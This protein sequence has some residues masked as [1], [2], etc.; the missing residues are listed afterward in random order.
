MLVIFPSSAYD[1]VMDKLLSKTEYIMYREC[2]QNAWV[3]RHR[4]DIHDQ[5]EMSEFEESLL[6]MGNE[7]EELARG[8]FPEGYL[9]ERRS[10]GAVE[11]TKQLISERK[12]IIFQAVFTTDAYLAA[13]DVMVWNEGAGAYDLYEIKMSSTQ[14]EDADGKVKVDRKKEERYSFDLAF[15]AQ[16]VEACG[17]KLHKKYLVRLNRKYVRNGE[18]DYSQLFILEDRTKDMPAYQDLAKEEMIR[19]HAALQSTRIPEGRCPCFY[20]G[21]SKHCTTF[22]FTNPDVP[23]KNS[24]HDLNRIGSSKRYLRELLDAGILH[25]EHVPENEDLIKSEKKYNQVRVHKTQEPLIN[26][27]ALRSEL[28]K[29]EFPLYF[30]DYEAYPTAIPPFSGYRPYQQIVF[31]YSLHVLHAPDAEVQQFGDLILGGDPSEKIAEQL[32]AHIGDKGSVIVWYKTYEDCRNRELAQLAPKYKD[33]FEHI[34]SRTYDLMDI[35][36]GQLY[37]HPG[38]EG[39][40]S[41]KKVLPVLVPEL[42]YAG[43]PVKSGTDAIEGYRQ[44][45]RGELEGTARD[46][47]QIDMLEYC[48]LDT[49][50][51]Y[52]IWK[53][54][55]AIAQ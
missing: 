30:L 29:L 15:Q 22:A 43:L 5:Y 46:Q 14:K 7:V 9:V 31:Q 48:K 52:E 54:F 8:M 47:K 10:E 6:E 45:T 20:R 41:I 26:T 34:I 37:V 33:F 27:E 49:L 11:L 36:E 4:S 17:V 25:I 39:R 40:A 2:P 53:Q 38:F 32:R 24:V 28:S 19:A 23:Q 3:R 42:S 51:M 13:T 35:V 44:L 55:R 18:L 50:A 21:R 16:V 12:P 1:S